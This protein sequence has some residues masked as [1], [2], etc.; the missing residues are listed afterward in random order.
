MF[1]CLKVDATNTALPTIRADCRC[2]TGPSDFVNATSYSN[3]LLSV[4]QRRQYL[5]NAFCK[6]GL[7]SFPFV[8]YLE[9]LVDTNGDGTLEEKELR[10][11][12]DGSRVL[13][14]PGGTCVMNEQL[15]ASFP[16][17]GLFP[18]ISLSI[19]CDLV[20]CNFLLDIR[21]SDSSFE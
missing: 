2:T 18:A 13:M 21:H 7:V 3:Q 15:V 6:S 11:A 19:C 16:N 1:R 8:V 14:S 12:T 5:S 10:A 17:M 4:A 20:S 9:S